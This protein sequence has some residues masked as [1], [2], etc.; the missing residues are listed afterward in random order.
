MLSIVVQILSEGSGAQ[1]DGP[2][3]HVVVFEEGIFD[4]VVPIGMGFLPSGHKV[5]QQLAAILQIDYVNQFAV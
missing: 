2:R 1:L 5:H 4:V 3:N